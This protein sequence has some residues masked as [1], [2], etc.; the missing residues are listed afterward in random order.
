MTAA[1]FG[2][3]GVIVGG[4]L[5]GLIS[6]RIERSRE[7]REARAAARLVGVELGRARGGFV[8]YAILRG[9]KVPY[10]RAF[11]QLVSVLGDDA[12]RQHS[13]VLARTLDPPAWRTV[14][15]AFGHITFLLSPG[16]VDFKKTRL[17]SIAPRGGA[18]GLR[19]QMDSAIVALATFSG[20]PLPWLLTQEGKTEIGGLAAKI[21]EALAPDLAPE[22]PEEYEQQPHPTPA[23]RPPS[24]ASE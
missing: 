5:S 17:H 4:V 13:G 8:S 23:E 10:E 14:A 3:L 9:A 18:R 6:W 11:P 24:K 1:I 12:W 15:N 21:K 7:R 19:D 16:P 22:P 2:L 20:D